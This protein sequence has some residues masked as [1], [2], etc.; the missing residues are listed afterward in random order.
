MHFALLHPFRLT[1]GASCWQDYGKGI[2][3][4]RYG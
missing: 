2:T 4:P 3:A 1:K